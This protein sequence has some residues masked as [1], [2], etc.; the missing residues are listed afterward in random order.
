MLIKIIWDF[1]GV[2]GHLTAIHHAIHL[3]EFCDNNKV[4]Y[5]SVDTE[6][7]SDIHTIAYIITQKENVVVIRDALKPH[8]AIVVE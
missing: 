3:K 7:L 2:D 8:R 1:K 6:K 5:Q 4:E